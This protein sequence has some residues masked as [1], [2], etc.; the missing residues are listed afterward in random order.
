M[1]KSCKMPNSYIKNDDVSKPNTLS[2]VLPTFNFTKKFI[3]VNFP[4]F[5]KIFRKL[6]IL[7]SKVITIAKRKIQVG[8]TDYYIYTFVSLPEK[9]THYRMKIM[10][11]MQGVKRFT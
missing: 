1:A 11:I 5:M 7:V 2:T 9:K 10:H 6:Y 8:N 4:Q 3:T